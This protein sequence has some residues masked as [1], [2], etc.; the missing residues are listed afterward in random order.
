MKDDVLI[1]VLV[2]GLE[3]LMNHIGIY[4]EGNLGSSVGSFYC[5]T[6]EKTYG[7]IAIKYFEEKDGCGNGGIRMWSMKLKSIRRSGFNLT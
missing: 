5:M 2:L 1:L 3:V 7:F 6:Y 4:D